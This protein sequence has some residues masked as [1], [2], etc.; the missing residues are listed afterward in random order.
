MSAWNRATIE[1]GDVG[2]AQD[3]LRR[4]G[5]PSVISPLRGGAEPFAMA[6]DLDCDDELTLARYDL[7]G[8]FSLVAQPDLFL[9]ARGTGD[10]VGWSAADDR[11]TFAGGPVQFAPGSYVV[12]VD[13]VAEVFAVQ[14]TPRALRRLGAEVHC[15]EQVRLGAGSRAPRSAAQGQ[16]W[17][18]VMQ[19]TRGLLDAGMLANEHLRA[20]LKANLAVTLL[21]TFSLV[22]GTR[23]WR[24]S[25]AGAV[26]AF[27][28]AV[29]FIESAATR[30]ISVLDVASAAGLP[31]R[32]LDDH[33]RDQTGIGVAEYLRLFRLIG[34][35]TQL[36]RAEPSLEVARTVV[37]RWGFT[38][39]ATFL[40]L[41][42]RA[43]PGRPL[44]FEHA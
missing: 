29:A 42:R 6:V 5:T 11:G 16:Y 14:F 31:F 41:H 43:Y 17:A 39:L 23:P 19:Y 9:V 24:L 15:V 32:L 27:R 12:Q 26:A 2:A 1:T 4:S 36:V 34:A 35:H 13:G 18:A 20:A 37:Q 44:P 30:P 8:T 10:E 22:E 7:G 25:S 40:P 21:D 3:V 38:S 28:R 33:F